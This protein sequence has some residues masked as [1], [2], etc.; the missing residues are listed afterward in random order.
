MYDPT[1]RS[2]CAP[3]RIMEPVHPRS[4]ET[5]QSPS[6]KRKG[7][8][9]VHPVL[10]GMAES[11]RDV[12]THLPHRR[13]KF[14]YARPAAA[15]AMTGHIGPR[16]GPRLVRDF[17]HRSVRMIAPDTTAGTN[18]PRKCYMLRD[19]VDLARVPDKTPERAL[20]PLVEVRILRGQSP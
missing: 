13:R 10:L 15:G 9:G 20:E 17:V 5:G 11:N 19:F 2:S 3:V 4:W 1:T 6:S 12:V 14:T 18:S 16:V 8:I 7:P